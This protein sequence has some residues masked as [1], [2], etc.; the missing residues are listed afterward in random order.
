MYQIDFHIYGKQRKKGNDYG[1]YGLIAPGRDHD[2]LVTTKDFPDPLLQ[3]VLKPH[4]RESES[5]SFAYRAARTR[6]TWNDRSF[7]FYR[8]HQ[9]E[10]GDDV[11]V[12]SKHCNPMEGGFGGAGRTFT[13][14]AT[15]AIRGQWD[16]DLIP[17]AISLL[18]NTKEHIRPDENTRHEHAERMLEDLTKGFGSL[19]VPVDEYW[20]SNIKD[21]EPLRVTPT[22]VSKH[23]RARLK[24]E[25]VDEES[26]EYQNDPNSPFRIAMRI[27]QR[28]LKNELYNIGRQ[29]PFA[30]SV[31]YLKSFD[32]KPELSAHTPVFLFD[33]VLLE[34]REYAGSSDDGIL[35]D[36]DKIKELI[37]DFGT[38]QE[39]FDIG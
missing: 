30:A 16:P 15:L 18:Y 32:G 11:M 4:M 27:K 34:D 20:K 2:P 26:P 10:D 31:D 35:T 3:A 21:A 28:L 39:Q 14:R 24:E 36:L 33:P 13:H 6:E 9:G 29:V 17:Y 8:H 19:S 23:L 37:Q 7:Y 5:A 38:P 22:D 1:P 12:F 25:P